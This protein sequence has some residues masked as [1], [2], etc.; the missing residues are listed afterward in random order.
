[1]GDQ[2]ITTK[3]DHGAMLI[4]EGRATEAFQQLLDQLQQ[5][6]NDCVLGQA[7]VLQTYTVAT[8]P[9]AASWLNGVIIVS[10]ETGGRTI[11][12]S[13]GTNWRRVSDGAVVS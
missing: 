5:V 8:V 1:M 11:A 9:A 10:D 7:L 13:D 12:T 6:L 2:L 4:V 3:P